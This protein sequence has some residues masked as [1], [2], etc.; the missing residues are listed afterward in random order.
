MPLKNKLIVILF[1][2]FF[3][4]VLYGSLAAAFAPADI[5]EKLAGITGGFADKRAEQSLF[6]TFLNSFA[7]NMLILAVVFVLGFSAVTQPAELFVPLFYGLG[8]GISM[9]YIYKTRLFEGV[10]YCAVLVIPHTVI[11]LIAIILAV[12]ESFFMSNLFLG[13]VVPKLT[14]ELSAETVKLY[15]LKALVLS[16]AVLIAA[17][18]DCLLTFIFAGLFV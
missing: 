8:L 12:R 1:V 4:G 9:G 11:S 18:A 14:G 15:S 6:I 17:A 16:G 5:I 7:S 10:V 13:C 2:L 3:A